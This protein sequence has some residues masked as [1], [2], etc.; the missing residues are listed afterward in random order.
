MPNLV[1]AIYSA[2][3]LLSL[4]QVFTLYHPGGIQKAPA[5]G[6]RFA[7]IHAGMTFASPILPA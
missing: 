1:L 4:V 6:W 7:P 3:E 5:F 2:A